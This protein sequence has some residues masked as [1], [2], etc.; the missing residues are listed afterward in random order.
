[1]LQHGAIR[2]IGS[3]ARLTILDH[4]RCKL[5]IGISETESNLARRG[6]GQVTAA[7]RVAEFASDHSFVKEQE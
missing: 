7:S 5:W 3:R 1:M 6:P 2:L 4:S